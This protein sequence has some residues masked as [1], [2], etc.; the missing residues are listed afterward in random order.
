MLRKLHTGHMGITKTLSRAQ[1]SMWYPGITVDIKNMIKQCN[2]CQI[3]STVQK[4]EPLIPRPLPDRPWQR[5]D[6][7]L[8]THQQQV[9][10]VVSDEYSRW[11]EIVKMN[12]DNNKC[13]NL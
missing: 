1:Q 11:L 6:I 13:G 8:L 5:I 7:D 3:H 2:H 4:A 12:D 10:M 9:Y